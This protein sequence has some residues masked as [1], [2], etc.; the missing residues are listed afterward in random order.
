VRETNLTTPGT[1]ISPWIVT[2]DALSPFQTKGPSQEPPIA[3]Y[4]VD[5][6]NRTYSVDMQVELLTGDESTIVT[7]SNTSCCYWNIGQMIA[8]VVSSGSGLRMGDLIVIGT[9]SGA[10]RES[11]ACLMEYTEGGKNPLEL[12]GGR[13]RSYLEDMDM[14]RITAMAGGEESGVGFGECL[15]QLLPSRSS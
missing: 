2:V 10:E 4:L 7:K 5:P 12:S 11:V 14:V 9:I 3:P 8:H 13:K 6:E 15:G 1:T